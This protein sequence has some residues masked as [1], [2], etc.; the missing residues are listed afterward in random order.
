MAA[1]LPLS[2]TDAPSNR[3]W[4]L[5]LP[6]LG[7]AIWLAAFGDKTPA[8]GK[9][10]VLPIHSAPSAPIPR[11]AADGGLRTP[12]VAAPVD[13]LEALVARNQLVP[14]RDEA[15]PSESRDL[16]AIR[17]WSPPPPPAPPPPEAPTSPV[18]PPLPYVYVGKKQEGQS[19]EVYLVRGEQTFIVRDGQTIEGQYKVE[20]IAPPMLT[21]TYLPLGQAQSLAIGDAL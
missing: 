14:T 3:R 20:H 4:W 1:R 19:W 8:S 12:H 15:T 17:T 13:A 7:L 5:L 11:S 6:M 9:A 21:L 2:P 10:P 18:A 16:F